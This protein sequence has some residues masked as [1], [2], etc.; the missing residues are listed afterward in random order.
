MKIVYLKVTN[1]TIPE[2]HTITYNFIHKNESHKVVSYKMI[3]RLVKG[4]IFLML[5][6]KGNLL[7]R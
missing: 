6:E 3:D 7:S 4:N 2:F 5:A 1:A